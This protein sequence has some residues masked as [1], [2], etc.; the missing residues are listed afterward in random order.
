MVSS[1]S[2][3]LPDPDGPQQT[4]I[5]SRGISTVTFLRLC[6]QAP[7]TLKVRSSEDEGRKT[8]FA[9]LARFSVFFRPLSFVLSSSFRACP[10]NDS[11]HAATCSGVPVQTTL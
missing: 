2:D 10:V 6:W 4:V 9:L 8:P 3:D 11:V 1:A 7:S 5:F